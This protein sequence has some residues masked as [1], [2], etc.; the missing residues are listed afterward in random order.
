MAVALS[1]GATVGF[2][3]NPTSVPSSSSRI[4]GGFGRSA[5]TPTAPRRST[6]AS[7]G[8]ADAIPA[9][10]KNVFASK[11][12]RATPRRGRTE[13]AEYYRTLG[14]TP[15]ADYM[16]VLA[17]TD[18]LKEKYAGDRKKV[19]QL[20][21]AKDD[22]MAL[23]LKQ[24]VKGTI[25]SSDEAKS[26]DAFSSAKEEFLK[27]RD[28]E[29]VVPEFLKGWVEPPDMDHMKKVGYR[30]IAFMLF[31]AGFPSAAGGLQMVGGANCLGTI[32]NR[33]APDLKRDEN[34]QI[35]EM[36]LPAQKTLL[37]SIV[38]MMVA[39]NVGT[40]F[41]DLLARVV[42]ESYLLVE[43]WRGMFVQLFYA[44][45]CLYVT[46]WR[47]PKDGPKIGRKPGRSARRD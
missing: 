34:G 2:L 39:F 4:A 35:A 43:S 23:R 44:I 31:T 17:A 12:T 30:Y 6:A 8:L 11:P 46:T 33:G 24:A 3:V 20:E 41:G 22:I 28:T 1:A 37:V 32:M 36:R 38:F 15:D 27:K 47:E 26:V 29:L 18:R 14:V 40:Q 13:G 7:M 5:S 45:T 19:I 25:K 42:G 21:K 9:P 10:L 16:E